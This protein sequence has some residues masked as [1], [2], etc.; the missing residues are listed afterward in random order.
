MCQIIAYL[1][2]LDEKDNSDAGFDEIYNRH[3]T[4]TSPKK[5]TIKRHTPITGENEQKSGSDNPPPY[6]EAIAAFDRA[7]EMSSNNYAA[8]G[9]RGF[10]LYKS[11]R[12]ED[13]ILS[14]DKAI[15]INPSHNLTWR[16][17]GSVL[18]K[19]G[20]DEEALIKFDKAIELN[21]DYYHLWGSKA[22]VLLTLERYEEAIL[23]YDKALELHP[24]E[25]NALYEKA[26]CYMGLNNIDLAIVNLKK[27]ISINPEEFREKATTDSDFDDIRDD[28]RFKALFIDPMGW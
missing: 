11:E 19:L 20:R 15:E 24:N 13:A 12:Y 14:L 3:N 17:Y 7:I 28:V 10:A 1:V 6:E 5:T 26:C 27:A 9:G 25:P 8:Y 4:G 2:H 23:F 21:P 18:H 22:F 16:I